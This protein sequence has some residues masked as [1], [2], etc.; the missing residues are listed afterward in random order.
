MSDVQLSRDLGF[1]RIGAA[2]PEL[3][4][5]NVDFNVAAII[6][7]LKKA[8]EEGVQIVSFPEM[9][10]TGYTLGDLVQQQALLLKAE[11]GLRD[12]LNEYSQSA[13]VV[14]VG[15]PLFVEQKI[16][17][18]AVVSSSGRILGVIPK[19]FLPSYKE[20]YEDRWFSSG[21]DTRSNTIELADPHI[22]NL[23]S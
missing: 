4:V 12:I 7:L 14:V 5:A 13:M 15:M 6:E 16:F 11:R 9:S 18:C 2:V 19:T 17:N 1:L 23:F 21:T 3:R 8:R 10:L 20:F 22:R